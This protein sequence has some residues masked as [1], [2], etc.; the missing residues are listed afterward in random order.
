MDERR[1]HLPPWNEAVS[2][3][4]KKAGMPLGTE[5]EI[6]CWLESNLEALREAAL[7]EFRELSM[8]IHLPLRYLNYFTACVLSHHDGGTFPHSLPLKAFFPVIPQREATLKG[9]FF[10]SDGYYRVNYS[11]RR[12]RPPGTSWEPVAPPRAFSIAWPNTPWRFAM[13]PCEADWEVLE[14]ISREVKERINEKIMWFIRPGYIFL[15]EREGEERWRDGWLFLG[16]PGVAGRPIQDLLGLSKETPVMPTITPV[17]V[18]LLGGDVV[19]PDIRGG[20][21]IDSWRQPMVERDPVIDKKDQELADRC[22]KVVRFIAGNPALSGIAGGRPP[23]AI[24]T[25][26]GEYQKYVE[27]MYRGELQ[28]LI[29]PPRQSTLRRI[30]KRVLRRAER[31]FPPER[32][33]P[34]KPGWHLAIEA[35]KPWRRR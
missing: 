32:R 26:D 1:L 28:G 21:L 20:A 6:D 3:V 9:G 8:S 12:P 14:K 15:D 22:E 19:W 24:P 10:T 13:H 35:E 2:R 4:R 30:R 27:E 11:P 5:A 23:V 18:V 7:D 29:D 31:H 33:G 25:P 16:G 17:P 34:L